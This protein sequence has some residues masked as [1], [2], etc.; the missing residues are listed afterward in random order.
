MNTIYCKTLGLCEIVA[1]TKESIIAKT[2][3]E[4]AKNNEWLFRKNEK[5][6]NWFEN[7]NDFLKAKE[8]NAMKEIRKA[9]LLAELEKEFA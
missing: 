5:G 6:L 7:E 9:E 8:I 3:H 1:E 4:F 2:K